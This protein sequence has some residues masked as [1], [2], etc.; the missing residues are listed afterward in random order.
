MLE[1]IHRGDEIERLVRKAFCFQIDEARGKL[2]L[3]EAPGAEIEQHRA[4]VGERHVEPVLDKEKTAG[5]DARAEIEN[6]TRAM[7]RSEFQ[8]GDI[9][10]RRIVFVERVPPHQL[11]DEQFRPVVEAFHM[12]RIDGRHVLVPGVLEGLHRVLAT[13][14]HGREIGVSDGEK[15]A[16]QACCA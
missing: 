13:P 16:R 4:D 1:D 2:A 9:G 7:T 6:V 3:S 14:A 15:R 8:R 5:A 10:Q 12:G 11:V